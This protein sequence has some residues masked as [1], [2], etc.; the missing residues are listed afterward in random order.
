VTDLREPSAPSPWEANERSSRRRAMI[1][2]T[3][4]A[5]AAVLVVVLMTHYLHAGMG[6]PNA[7]P[8]V[9]F[10]QPSTSAPSSATPHASPTH[11]A[12][13]SPTAA[14]P[15]TPTG[16]PCTGNPCAVPGDAGNAVA[17]VNGFRTAHGLQP[18]PGAVSTDAAQCAL[19]QGS[20]S[21]CRP[22]YAWE[23]LPAQDGQSCV[24]LVGQRDAPWLL[25]QGMQSFSVGWAY[26]PGQQQWYCALLKVG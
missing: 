6:S 9:L 7:Q 22:H 25:D 26:D 4:L 16:P 10:A 14:P 21:S 19:A 13:T 20:G 12:P 5:V 17:A 24:Q 3:A 15:T 23:T 2:L 8:S 1:V 18:V 11:P